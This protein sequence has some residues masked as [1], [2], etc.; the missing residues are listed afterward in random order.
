M[1]LRVD[2]KVHAAYVR[3][4]GKKVARTVTKTEQINVD[5]DARGQIVGFE[6]LDIDDGIDLDQ[7]RSVGPLHDELATLLDAHGLRSSPNAGVM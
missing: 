6:F 3:V 7:L 5:Y 2:P 1:E 4:T